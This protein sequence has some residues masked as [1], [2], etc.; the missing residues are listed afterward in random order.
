[1]VDGDQ[2]G[3]VGKGR[4][5]LDGFDHLRDAGHALVGGDDVGT[6]LHQVGDRSTVARALDHEIGDQGDGLGVVQLDTAFK[7]AEASRE[8]PSF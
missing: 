8:T 7:P 4:L 1:M 5:D 6:R 2:L 3:A